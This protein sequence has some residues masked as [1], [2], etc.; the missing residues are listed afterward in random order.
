[1]ADS[2][3]ERFLQR[4]VSVLEEHMADHAF[5]VEALAEA[6]RMSRTSLYLKLKAA[7]GQNPQDFI[8]FRRLRRAARLLRETGDH[9]SDIATQV[10]WL[11]HTH[12][13]RAF[14]NHFGC[15]PSEY[16]KMKFSEC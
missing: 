16:R 15:S 11:E 7:T 6:L 3:G 8:R 2:S 14:R 9:V 1:M 4:V 12:F 13:D 5:G 10:G